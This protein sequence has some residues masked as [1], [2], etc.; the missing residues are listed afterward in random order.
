M[1]KKYDLIGD[2]HGNLKKLISL[3]KNMGYRCENGLWIHDNR[4]PV[5]AGDFVDRGPQQRELIQLVS[6][7]CSAGV[8]LAVM[9]NHEFNAISYFM[10]KIDGSG[11]YLR[12]HNKRNYDSHKVFLD[13][14]KGD[15][16]GYAEAIYWM[17]TLPLFLELDGIRVV[18]ACWEENLVEASRYYIKDDNSLEEFAW[19]LCHDKSHI[20]YDVAETLLKG[21]ES[22]LPK[23]LSYKDENGILRNK[24]RISWW[25]EESENICDIAITTSA[26]RK[27]LPS[28]INFDSFNRY[29]YMSDIPVFFGHYWFK[30]DPKVVMPNMVC[31]DY[32]AA[33]DGDLVAYRWDGE[34]TLSNNKFISSN[35]ISS[36]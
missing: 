23:E 25:Q 20:M 21:P 16:I 15:H 31:L 10:K 12:E 19:H 11:E 7:M 33:K 2:I 30:G 36:C 35:I 5:F 27:L 24:V 1:I 28:A 22:T 32:S 34:E 18:H 8:A 17:K 14:Y 4:M 13:A 9:G 6:S 3:F 26:H 29:Q